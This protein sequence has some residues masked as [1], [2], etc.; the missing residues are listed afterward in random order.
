MSQTQLLALSELTNN[1]LRFLVWALMLGLIGA[2]ACLGGCYALYYLRAQTCSPLL[3]DRR[4]PD[5]RRGDAALIRDV[6]RGIAEIEAFLDA[7]TAPDQ[8]R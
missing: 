3:P 5:R 8:P 2:G 7:H 6:E 4:H 1:L